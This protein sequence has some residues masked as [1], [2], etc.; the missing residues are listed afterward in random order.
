MSK[1]LM[2]RPGPS[3]WTGVAPAVA[4][5]IVPGVGQMANGEFDK[6]LGVLI[7][8]AVAGASVIGAIPLVGTIAGA[9]YTCTWIYGVADGYF[10]ARKKAK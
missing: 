10:S 5:A 6:G 9:V 2:K 1:A 3:K 4:S 7:T 8:A